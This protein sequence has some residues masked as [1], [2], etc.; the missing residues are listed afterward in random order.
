MV[1]HSWTYKNESVN[2]HIKKRK[3][4][5]MNKI[6]ERCGK[7]F[8]VFTKI[9]YKIKRYCSAECTDGYYTKTNNRRKSND[10]IT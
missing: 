4:I 8:Q 5:T 3:V 10:F 9:A 2:K 1:H 7:E 6:C